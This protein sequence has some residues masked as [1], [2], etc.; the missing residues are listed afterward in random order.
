MDVVDIES[1]GRTFQFQRGELIGG[2]FFSDWIK[3]PNKERTEFGEDRDAVQINNGEKGWNISDKNVEEQLEEQIETFWKEFKV[4]IDYVMRFVA[5]KEGTSLQYVGRE[6]ID[7]K[8]VDILEVRDEER[9]RINLYVE[10]EQGTLLKKTVR[11]LS[12]PTIFEEVYSNYHLIQGVFT[13][14]LIRRYTNGI[15]TMEIRF[16]EYSYNNGISDKAFTPMIMKYK[17]D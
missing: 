16:D 6:M 15:K 11:R 10:R 13:P 17:K 5:G 7:F 2:N 9:T 8:R 3:F 4:S 1:R 14:L 12:E